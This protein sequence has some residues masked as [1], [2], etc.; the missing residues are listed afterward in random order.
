[1]HVEEISQKI[2]IYIP[3]VHVC[4]CGLFIIGYSAGFG[5]GIAD[6]FSVSD[7]FTITLKYLI[8]IYT[9]G[10]VIPL[11][12]ILIRHKM[13]YSYAENLID[14]IGDPE[15]RIKN[16]EILSSIRGPMTYGLI[17][18]SVLCA[19]ML[20]YQVYVDGYRNYYISLIWISIGFTTVWAYLAAKLNIFGAK[21][22]VSWSIL[23]F[24]VSVFGYAMDKGFMDRRMDYDYFSNDPMRCNDQ[25]ILSTVGSYFI[26][27]SRD[28][29]RLIISDDCKTKFKIQNTAP[30]SERSISDLILT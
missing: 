27:V 23:I 16:M 26:S 12:L 13:G 6:L 2:A 30:L 22:E 24:C 11:L 19:I 10:L 5:S 3:V 7:F 18:S 21:V 25:K 9:S 8:L 28:N 15:V 14:S 4:V 20:I 1:M 29:S 17:T